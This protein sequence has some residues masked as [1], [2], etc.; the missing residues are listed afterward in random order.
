MTDISNLIRAYFIVYIVQYECNIHRA[1]CNK[2]LW[3]PYNTNIN[4]Q[5]S[6]TV[7]K[8]ISLAESFVRFTHTNL[9]S[10]VREP[11]WDSPEENSLWWQRGHNKMRRTAKKIKTKHV[12]RDLYDYYCTPTFMSYQRH[13]GW[14]LSDVFQPRELAISRD[15]QS[16]P[17]II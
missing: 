8:Q 1:Q 10:P 5:L 2:C 6:S 12:T 4:Q 11:S 9:Y 13:V 3:R 17:F 14:C 15:C 7:S 16:L